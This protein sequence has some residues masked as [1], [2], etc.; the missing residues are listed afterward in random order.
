VTLAEP[1]SPLVLADGT[2]I[3]PST[4]N[5][6]RER[7]DFYEVPSNTQAQKIVARVNRSIVDLPAPPEKMNYISLVIMYKLMGL[8][9]KDVALATKTTLEQVENVQTLS[10]YDDC[11]AQIRDAVVQ[12]EGES[13]KARFAQ[14]SRHAAERVFDLLQSEDEKVALL[15][16]KDVLDRAGHRPVDVIEQRM[17]FDNPLRIEY[18]KRD[19]LSSVPVIEGEFQ[20]ASASNN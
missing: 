9:D 1:N 15:A 2:K 12:H 11:L 3:D 16:S 4:G 10:I 14:R 19:S 13:V 18:V 17:S 8:N 5:V 20:N 7:R 6:V